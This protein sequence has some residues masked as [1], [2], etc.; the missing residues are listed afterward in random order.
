MVSSYYGG[1]SYNRNT[2]VFEW[3]PTSG[4]FDTTPL[5]TIPARGGCYLTP[6]VIDGR[7]FIM[8]GNYSDDTT[9]HKTQS[10][11]WAWN[12]GTKRLELV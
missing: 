6:F 12:P 7:Q 5:Q 3:N 2:P 1:S 4:M 10:D 9:K 8:V 11:L